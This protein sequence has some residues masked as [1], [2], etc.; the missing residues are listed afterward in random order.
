[1]AFNHRRT[2]FKVRVYC[3][4]SAAPDLAWPFEEEE[5]RGQKSFLPLSILD[6]DLV[7][8]GKKK[9]QKNIFVALCC[10]LT[11][12][13]T[14]L[15]H[16]IL[17]HLSFSKKAIHRRHEHMHTR[18]LLY[19]VAHI[20]IPWEEKKAPETLTASQVPPYVC[21]W[22][23]VSAK[24]FNKKRPWVTKYVSNSVWDTVWV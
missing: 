7:W 19:S 4:P 18:Q 1:M 15:G 9:Q 3:A 12:T 14:S 24:K 16:N 8:K 21:V 11:R 5:E 23:S 20:P 6:K 2:A 22:L 13:Q 10:W 17:P